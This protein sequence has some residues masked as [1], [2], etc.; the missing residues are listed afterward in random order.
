MQNNAEI[1]LLL[2][3]THLSLVGWDPVTT[4]SPTPNLALFLTDLEL[5][6]LPAFVFFQQAGS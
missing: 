3:S 1:C 2:L 4:I 6:N 5:S